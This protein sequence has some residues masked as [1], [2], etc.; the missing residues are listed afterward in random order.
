MAF[1]NRLALWAAVS[2]WLNRADLDSDMLTAQTLVE[3]TLRRTLRVK[4]IGPVALSLTGPVVALPVDCVELRSIELDR[5]SATGGGAI[6]ITTPSVLATHRARLDGVTGVPAFAAISENQLLLAP[7]PNA[8]FVATVFY[9]QG[10]PTL[11]T[12][13]ATNWLLESAP[14]IYFFGMLLQFA[15]YLKEDDR[16]A[17]WNAGFTK[18]LDELDQQR[19]RQEYRAAPLHRYNEYVF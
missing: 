5:S 4:T 10:L 14:D 17:V 18:A 16:I 2:K 11:A 8:V 6:G 19:A 7:A 1:A 15:P 13:V 3:A 9:Y 12:D